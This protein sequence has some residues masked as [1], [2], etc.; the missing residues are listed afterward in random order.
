MLFYIFLYSNICSHLSFRIF[1]KICRYVISLKKDQRILKATTEKFQKLYIYIRKKLI[2]WS[3]WKISRILNY[4]IIFYW[5]MT[6]I[7]IL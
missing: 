4:F 2:R 1:I 7:S 6:S 3:F 5:R